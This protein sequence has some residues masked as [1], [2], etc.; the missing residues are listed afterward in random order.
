MHCRY[1]IIILINLLSSVAGAQ[2]LVYPEGNLIATRFN[3]PTGYTRMQERD[4]TTFFVFVQNLPLLPNG[5]PVVYSNKDAKPANS[6]RPAAVLNMVLDEENLQQKPQ[7]LMRL[8]AEYL[9][10]QQQFGDIIFHIRNGQPIA[11]DKW[12]EGLKG[13]VEGT[14]Y[15]TKV[16]LDLKAYTTFRRYLNFV[17]RYSDFQT[18]QKDWR[19]LPASDLAPGSI[20]FAEK[21][22]NYAAVMILDVAIN[23]RGERLLILACG[24]SPAQSIEVLQNSNTGRTPAQQATNLG[25]WFRVEKDGTVRTGDA[26]FNINTDL[27]HF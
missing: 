16:P 2:N 22:G 3:V 14:G 27:Y 15:W 9:F 23:E 24:G 13:I 12:K 1:Y 17:F 19:V 21:E 20:L 10:E 11:Y 4:R 26:V 6:R 18:I 7:S 8:W 25:P 5:T